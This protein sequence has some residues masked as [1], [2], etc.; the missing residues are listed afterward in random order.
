MDKNLFYTS[1]TSEKWKRIGIKKRAGV[2]L[3]LFSIHSKKSSGIG[4]IPDLKKMVDWC[5]I[6]GLSIIQLL[7]LN[8]VGFDFS[9]YNAISTFALEPMYLSFDDLRKTDLRPFRKDIRGLKNK[10]L[11]DT[12]KVNYE[13]KKEKLNLLKKIYST[14]DLNGIRNFEIFVNKNKQWLKYYSLFRILTDMHNGKDWSD[15]E[16]KYAYISSMT[17][18]KILRENEN[19]RN[20]Y[21]WL[22]WQ[23]Y[24][25]LRSVKKYASKKEILIMGDLPFLVSRNSADVWAYK[26]YFKL[27]LSSGAPPDMYFSKGQRWGMPPYNWEN[28]ETQNFVYIKQR[29][30]YASN[31]YDMFRID[32]FVGLFRIWTISKNEPVENAGYNGKFDPEEEYY[33][34]GHG[35]KILEEMNDSSDMLPCAEDLGTVPECS[36]KVLKEFGITGIDVMRWEK[37]LNQEFKSAGSYRV[38]SAA[39]VSTHDS[40][41]LPAWWKYEAGT[42]DEF[43]FSKVCGSLNIRDGDYNYLLERLFEGNLHGRLSWK[44]E[45][46]N[47]YVLLE[48]LKMDYDQAREIVSLYL[49]SFSERNSFLKFIGMNESNPVN[50]I[51]VAFIKKTLEKIS[52]TDSIFS[53]Q[54]LMEYLYLDKDILR[55]YSGGDF[56]INSPGTVSGDNWSMRLPVSLEELLEMKINTDIKNL[57]LDSDR[58]IR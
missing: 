28:I 23:L 31:F 43:T 36:D 55:N 3:P 45:I 33:W 35:R 1:R 50:K 42:I 7:P 56:R 52:E 11:K 12:L 54:L 9:P 19:E 26:N 49:S 40:S 2:A 34:E 58:L 41:S 32:H 46:R 18:E 10:F 25:Q 22:Q 51:T 8:E 37:N 29:L 14:V 6:T 21:F 38:N 16:L 48:T 39:T 57:N 13:I 44:K 24:E 53:I 27:N 30:K 4:E 15:W 17:A 5:A 20:F 47:V